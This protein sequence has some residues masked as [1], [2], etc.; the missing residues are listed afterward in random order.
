[1]VKS[2]S[3][4]SA[5][6][7]VTRPFRGSSSGASS[8]TNDKESFGLWIVMGLEW[9]S[10]NH[11]SEFVRGQAAAWLFMALHALRAEQASDCAIQAW[12][13]YPIG[14]TQLVTVAAVT[15]DKNPDRS[16]MRPRPV[17]GIFDGLRFPGRA[18]AELCSAILRSGAPKCILC[19]TDSSSG[20]PTKATEWL[21]MGVHAEDTFGVPN[22]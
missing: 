7:P 20:D 17:W 19:D 5:R 15:K 18:R 14:G 4:T 8:R 2:A 12:A 11:E 1:M 9:I 10:A 3:P 22:L 13:S 21:A 6:A 16:K